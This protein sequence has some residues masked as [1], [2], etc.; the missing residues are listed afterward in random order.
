MIVRV[1]ASWSSDMTGDISIWS[2]PK[3]SSS[4][5][6]CMRC[7]T[8]NETP[9]CCSPSRSVLSSMRMRDG[10]AGS[11]LYLAAWRF[12]SSNAPVG[13]A[14]GVISLA[15]RKP[16]DLAPARADPRAGTRRCGGFRAYEYVRSIIVVFVVV[17]PW[18]LRSASML[19]FMLGMSGALSMAMMS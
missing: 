10:P 15:A 13:G 5:A 7:F 9:G 8:L 14:P 4:Q 12:A 11:S 3:W 2:T 16:R 6:I 18:T 1:A 17:T 19:S